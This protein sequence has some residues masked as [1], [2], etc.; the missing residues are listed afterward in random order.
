MGT[1]T[2]RKVSNKLGGEEQGAKL[3]IRR[4][5]PARGK[6]EGGTGMVLTSGRIETMQTLKKRLQES[7]GGRLSKY[8]SRAQNF[9]MRGGGRSHQEV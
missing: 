5:S 8:C 6:G 2:E 4:H 3:G 7:G 1:T 9:A